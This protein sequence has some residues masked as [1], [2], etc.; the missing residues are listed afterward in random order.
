M[1]TSRQEIIDQLQGVESAL[2]DVL[3]Q[4]A[5]AF[6][7]HDFRAGMFMKGHEWMRE[8]LENAKHTKML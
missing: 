2:H 4:S 7:E 3:E 6:A 1:P 8:S 5:A